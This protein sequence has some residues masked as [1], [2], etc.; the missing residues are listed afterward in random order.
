MSAS[1]GPA[2]AR[3]PHSPRLPARSSFDCKARELAWQYG[4]QLAPQR[5][6]FKSLFDA[7]QL[8]GCSIPNPPAEDDSWQT[9]TL[10]V[11]AAAEG[12]RAV[13]YVD[14]ELGDDGHDGASPAAPL[15]TL[16]AAVSASR[17]IVAA[18]A[19]P[20]PARHIVVKG[21]HHLPEPLH[22]TAEDSGLHLQNAAGLP[23]TLTG[24][25]ALPA[26]TWRPYK[27]PPRPAPPGAGTPR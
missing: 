5:G 14:A 9:P 11:P 24:A 21:T 15:R 20:V 12:S 22:L 8:G 18:A 6:S 13:I 19:D 7:L 3:P 10:A 26:L 2:S 1:L 25:K 17:A 4:K 16:Q 27:P 23:A